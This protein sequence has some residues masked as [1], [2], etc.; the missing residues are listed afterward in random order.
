MKV[1]SSPQNDRQD[2]YGTDSGCLA[3]RSS[4]K[5]KAYFGVWNVLDDRNKC[6]DSHIYTQMRGLVCVMVEKG[7]RKIGVVCWNVKEIK[8]LIQNAV[9]TTMVSI[10]I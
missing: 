2:S 5:Q 10:N 8:Q 3:G 4:A 6:A 7:A 9:E 1:V